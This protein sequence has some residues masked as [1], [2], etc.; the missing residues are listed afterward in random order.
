MKVHKAYGK[1]VLKIEVRTRRRP[2]RKPESRRRGLTGVYPCAGKL[3]PFYHYLS[4]VVQQI[5]HIVNMNFIRRI[6]NIPS[7]SPSSV[8]GINST[9]LGRWNLHYDPKIV[10]SKVD[11]ANEDHC[12]CCNAIIQEN[13][14]RQQMQQVQKRKWQER[15]QQQQQQRNYA[16]TQKCS[17][18]DD[19]YIP[20]FM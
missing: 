18:S 12:G 3:K 19:Y 11:Q 8:N 16:Q 2:S 10:H 17:E 9:K 13:K 4:I 7:S 14:T 15:Q 20:Y 1:S 6:F 5:I